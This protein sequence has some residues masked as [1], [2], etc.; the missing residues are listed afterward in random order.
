MKVRQLEQKDL[1]EADLIVRLAFGTFMGDPH[2]EEFG[3]GMDH[4]KTRWVAEPSAALAAEADGKLVGS[5]F[6]ARWG[7]FGFFGPLTVH[8]D[9]WNKGIAK[10]LLDSTMELFNKWG[11]RHVALFT[12]AQSPK[13]LGLYEKYGF[14]PRFLTPI[15]SKPV[16]KKEGVEGWSKFSDVPDA[17]RGRI[18]ERCRSVTGSI[19]GGL[20]LERE[21]M[22]VQ[23]QRLGDTVLLWDGKTLAGLAVCHCGEGTEAGRDIC[24]VKFGAISKGPDA[25]EYFG[26]L[27]S[28]CESL[29]AMCGMASVLAGVNTACHDA[30]RRMLNRGF[31]TDFL[32]VLMLKPNE[33]A[34]DTPDSYVI[35][36]LR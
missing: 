10:R 23:N 8:P 17:E 36:D 25:G 15:L 13:H 14:W 28:A 31:Q 16:E 27:L 24:Y 5:N 33:P 7:S 21:V 1:Q 34:F 6:A 32:G 2:P 3:E 18:L 12:L 22:A 19:Y 4:V 26:R 30:Y 20:D 11:V 29:A 35:C 9:F